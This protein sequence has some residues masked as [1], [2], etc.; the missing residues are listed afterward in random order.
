MSEQLYFF[1]LC[2]AEKRF[3]STGR[4]N[5]EK[6]IDQHSVEMHASLTI[7]LFLKLKLTWPPEILVTYNQS[8]E[9]SQYDEVFKIWSFG[10]FFTVLTGKVSFNEDLRKKICGMVSKGK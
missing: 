2:D 5:Q 3:L 7:N 10:L 9:T 6:A 1:S 8:L 4:L